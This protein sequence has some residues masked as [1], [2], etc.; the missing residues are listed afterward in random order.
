MRVME[1]MA[2]MMAKDKEEGWTEVA[3]DYEAAMEYSEWMYEE[4][5]ERS[6]SGKGEDFMESNFDEDRTINS[7]YEEEECIKPVNKE[8]LVLAGTVIAEDDRGMGVIEIV[9]IIVEIYIFYLYVFNVY[10]V[11]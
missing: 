10:T 5:E 11:I 9:L 7:E 3:E 6:V 1:E 4:E 8:N 2:E